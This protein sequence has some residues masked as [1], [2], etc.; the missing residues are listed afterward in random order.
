M[1]YNLLHKY[2]R[3]NFKPGNADVTRIDLDQIEVVWCKFI[4]SF[5]LPV[6]NGSVPSS[7]PIFDDTDESVEK[8]KFFD[9]PVFIPRSGNSSAQVIILL[10]G[11]NER[12]WDKYLTWAYSLAVSTGKSVILFPIPNHINR[13]PDSWHDPRKM[14]PFVAMRTKSGGP[15]PETSYANVAIS[16]RLTNQPERFFLSGYQAA[17]DIIQLC[18]GIRNGEHHLFQNAT[19]IDFF[20]YSIGVMLSQVL[21]IANPM[22]LFSASKFF[23]FCGGCTFNDMHGSSKYILD[24]QA[25]S[26]LSEFY[27][28][29]YN[30]TNTKPGFFNE[31][32]SASLL[33]KAFRMIVSNKVM[34]HARYAYFYKVRNRLQTVCLKKDKIIPGHAVRETLKGTQVDE[35]DFPFGYSHENPFPIFTDEKIKLVNLAFDAIFNKATAFLM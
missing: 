22:G 25:F 32:L 7:Q 5:S 1:Q 26:R 9:Y 12:T 19:H 2:L 34:Q 24:N 23:F 21:L 11:L 27:A 3:K 18:S 31:L 10:H 20:A 33:G 16:E 28:N 8:N 29:V 30:T 15:V 35:M 13:S 6:L 14:Q 4:S 17:S